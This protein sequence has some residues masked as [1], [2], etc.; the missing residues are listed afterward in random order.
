MTDYVNPG[1]A[2]TA[3][4]ALGVAES[5][6]QAGVKG[7]IVDPADS[8]TAVAEFEAADATVDTTVLDG[9]FNASWSGT[10]F[11]VT[12][13][14]GEGWLAGYLARDTSTT[15]TLNSNTTTVVEV[16]WDASAIDSDALIIAAEGDTVWAPEDPRLPIWEFTTGDGGVTDAVDLRPV[17][18]EE[19]QGITTYGRKEAQEAFITSDALDT[20]RNSTSNPHDVTATQTNALPLSGG[21]MSGGIETGTFGDGDEFLYVE[22]SN[23]DPIIWRTG[24]SGS[25]G[26]QLQYTGTGT[27]NDNALDLY[28]DNQD[29]TGRNWVWE[30]LQDATVDFKGTPSK[31]GNPLVDAE[32]DY[33]IQKNGTDGTGIINFHTK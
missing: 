24:N 1:A 5:F 21:K 33:T 22:G 25:Y 29:N 9:A 30:I 20:H 2:G 27:G 15:I 14:P 11:D 32:S 19:A 16:G 18:P 26:F 6:R 3:I 10:S 28:T 4:N 7:W 13:D 12:I 23:N 8:P 31:N 17:G